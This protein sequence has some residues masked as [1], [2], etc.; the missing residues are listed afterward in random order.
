VEEVYNKF[1]IKGD[2]HFN[3]DG[4]LTKIPKRGGMGMQ[5]PI[6]RTHKK[7]GRNEPCPCGSG[8]KYKKC[9]L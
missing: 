2:V 9:H 4:T 5:E 7:I 1:Y 6:T 3:K 8:I